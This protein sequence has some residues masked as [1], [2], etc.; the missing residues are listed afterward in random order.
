MRV[1]GGEGEG[2]EEMVAAAVLAYVKNYMGES[3][4]HIHRLCSPYKC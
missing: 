2:V 3:R 4:V 1:G